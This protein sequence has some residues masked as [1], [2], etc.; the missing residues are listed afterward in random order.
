[1]RFKLAATALVIV[2]AA[3][4]AAD[5]VQLT[6]GR[7]EIL[8][9]TSAARDG[10]AI[11]PAFLPQAVPTYRCLSPAIAADPT[12]YFLKAITCGSPEGRA[13]AGSVRIKTRCTSPNGVKIS[14]DVS[15]S[16]SST[17][18]DIVTHSVGKLS[19]ITLDTIF[20]DRARY[21]GSCRGDESG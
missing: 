21:V 4:L 19:G 13:A 7:W 2:P 20:H 15:G 12:G 5:T 8:S 10:R 14:M 17:S 18:Y 16:Y 6:A 1:M 11:P 9:A 3:A